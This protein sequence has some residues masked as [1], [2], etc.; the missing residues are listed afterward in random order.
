MII[1]IY[2]QKA[3]TDMEYDER[4]KYFN[5]WTVIFFRL[6]ILLPFLYNWLN[7]NTHKVRRIGC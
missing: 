5:T 7:L 2:L 1:D 3:K 6:I 4:V